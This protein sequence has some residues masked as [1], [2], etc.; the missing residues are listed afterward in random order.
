VVLGVATAAWGTVAASRGGPVPSWQAALL[1]FAVGALCG[2]TLV[3]LV[4]GVADRVRLLGLLFGIAA[5]LAGAAAVLGIGALPA[6]A[7]AGAVLA[8]R[9]MLPH[10]ILKVAH[11]LDAPLL[12]ALLVLVGASW[13]EAAFSW[14]TLAVLVVARAAGLMVAGRVLAAVAQQHGVA[15][16]AQRPWCGLLAQG[17][18][19][20]GFSL[21]L[22]GTVVDDPGVLAAAVT[23]LLVNHGLAALWTRRELFP[24]VSRGRT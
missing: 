3:V 2:W 13:T 12:V 7:V 8:N 20:L 1:P 23:A 22:V 14:P 6:A 19:A 5:V 17:E 11:A 16:A 21:V 24:T 18:L 10:R 9:A 4:R 15:L